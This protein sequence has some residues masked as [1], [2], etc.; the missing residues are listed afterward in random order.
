MERR[1]FASLFA[2]RCIERVQTA[3]T[4]RIHRAIMAVLMTL[5]VACVASR[6]TVRSR[7]A[8]S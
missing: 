7:P 3:I 2:A 1:T 6:G 5:L 8:T 4:A